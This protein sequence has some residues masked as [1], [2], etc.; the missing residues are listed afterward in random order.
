MEIPLHCLYLLGAKVPSLLTNVDAVFAKLA[1]K[2]GSTD[3]YLA[4]TIRSFQSRMRSAVP[5]RSP[6]TAVH[7]PPM[8][9][10]LV[11]GINDVSSAYS[12]AYAVF[13]NDK[14]YQNSQLTHFV[15]Q[16]NSSSLL[17]VPTDSV[18][19]ISG[20]SS[21]LAV[22]IVHS[23]DSAKRTLNVRLNVMNRSTLNVMNA[24]PIFSYHGHIE[25]IDSYLADRITL[26]LLKPLEMVSWTKIFRL[27]QFQCNTLAVKIGNSSSFLS[28][29]PLLPSLCPFFFFIIL[30][31]L[32][33]PP[34]PSLSFSLR[35]RHSILFHHHL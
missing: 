5:T 21:I 12:F 30:F 6:F 17:H 13:Q 22:S 1:K 16:E 7:C 19:D 27:N 24:T 25:V 3:M 28:L 4:S 14:E 2:Y 10:S 23:V 31:S 35:I 9:I 20:P 26:P 33:R 18:L 11:E 15:R 29:F 34:P 8:P 32:L